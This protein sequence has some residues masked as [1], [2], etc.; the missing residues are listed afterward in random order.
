MKK[1]K[2]KEENSPRR[3]TNRLRNS[4]RFS[5]RSYDYRE[6]SSSS[7]FYYKCEVF[8]RRCGLVQSHDIKKKT[9]SLANVSLAVESR[10]RSRQSPFDRPSLS[11]SLF[12]FFPVK[13]ET[14]FWVGTVR[15]RFLSH[16]SIKQCNVHLTA[17]KRALR[18]CEKFSS[19]SKYVLATKIGHVIAPFFCHIVFSRVFFLPFFR[20]SLIDCLNQRRRYKYKCLKYMCRA[21]DTFGC[22]SIFPK[23]SAN[24]RSTKTYITQCASLSLFL[25]VSVCFYRSVNTKVIRIV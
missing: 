4:T 9:T 7:S 1:K 15:R 2:K 22:F 5:E 3:A 16:H 18:E 25:S 13:M 14:K 19:Y 23:H 11:L 8:S 6:T 10:P 12:F 24:N 17:K 20:F 21:K